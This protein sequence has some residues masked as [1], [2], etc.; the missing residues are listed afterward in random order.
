VETRQRN[1]RPRAARSCII[2]RSQFL[3]SHPRRSSRVADPSSQTL[4]VQAY[5]DRLRGGDVAARGELLNC[6]CERLRRLTRKMIKGYPK[7]H[8]WEQTDDVLQNAVIRLQRTLQQL[9]VTAARD[10][11]PLAA[12]QIRRELLDLA[13]HYYGQ[14]GAGAHHAS[15]AEAPAESGQA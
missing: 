6:A 13:K 1:R 2:V 9:T 12:L 14:Q 7:V 3:P 5:L 15:H 4:Q 10:F 11:F 8:R